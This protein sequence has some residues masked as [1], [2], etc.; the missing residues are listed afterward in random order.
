[1]VSR[2]SGHPLIERRR[3]LELVPSSRAGSGPPG[4]GTAPAEA[5]RSAVRPRRPL[6]YPSRSIVSVPTDQAARRGLP[7]S[8]PRR[9]RRRGLP[10]S[11]PTPTPRRR[12]RPA[13]RH[14]RAGRTSRR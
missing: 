10:V 3:D 1:V 4:T 2:R 12:H 14:S 7:R 6:F 5:R 11:A 8:S 13:A 9:L